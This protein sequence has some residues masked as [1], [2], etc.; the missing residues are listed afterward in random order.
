MKKPSICIF[1]EF[2]NFLYFVYFPIIVFLC[3]RQPEQLQLIISLFSLLWFIPIIGSVLHFSILYFV[4]LCISLL[5]C[6]SAG[7]ISG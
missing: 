6:F 3:S 4:F 7:A 5:L 1:S 2:L